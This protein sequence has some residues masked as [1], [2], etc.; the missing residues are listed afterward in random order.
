MS[1][2]RRVS[3]MYPESDEEDE[4]EEDEEYSDDGSQETRVALKSGKE[5]QYKRKGILV[6]GMKYNGV[7]QEM[8]EEMTNALLEIIH[9]KIS[10]VREGIMRVVYTGEEHV[11][12]HLS[13]QGVIERKL[14]LDRAITT[15]LEVLVTD[16]MEEWEAAVE[17]V[18]NVRAKTHK[19]THKY[20][21]IH[22]QIHTNTSRSL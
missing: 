7:V 5:H 11:T 15:S 3:R 6:Q 18:H 22:T 8:R 4:E 13:R 1:S 16:V 2:A 10:E 17:S 21:H 14:L 12:G 19:H 20:T 9:M